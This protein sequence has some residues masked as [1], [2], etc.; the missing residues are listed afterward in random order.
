M[1]GHHVLYILNWVENMLLCRHRPY[2]SLISILLCQH[3]L[4]YYI[5]ISAGQ[6]LNLK[7]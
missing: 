1:S 6:V 4:Y 3:I 2:L 7:H 5:V